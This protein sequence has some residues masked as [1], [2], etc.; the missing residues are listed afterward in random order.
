MKMAQLL[1]GHPRQPGRHRGA[2]QDDAR[3]PG[4]YLGALAAQLLQHLRQLRLEEG[5]R[6]A[7]QQAAAAPSQG[8]AARCPRNVWHRTATHQRPRRMS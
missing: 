1:P 4:Q 3:R 6:L 7:I 5:E 8:R 2:Q